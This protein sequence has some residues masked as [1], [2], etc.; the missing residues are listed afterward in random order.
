MAL[1][2]A[3]IQKLVENALH[4]PK[5]LA[6]ELELNEYANAAV[7]AFQRADVDFSDSLSIKELRILCSEMG[8]P[9]ED[10]EEE[11]KRGKHFE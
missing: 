3:D 6:T 4:T 1:S 10:D 5:N 2:S 8:L 7:F 11:G 9:M